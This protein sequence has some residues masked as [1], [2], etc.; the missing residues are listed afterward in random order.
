MKYIHV[1]LRLVWNI[2]TL[3]LIL[4]LKLIA[5]MLYLPLKLLNAVFKLFGGI[6]TIAGCI[7]SILSIIL[8]VFSHVTHIFANMEDG[9]NIFYHALW[10][11]MTLAIAA[12]PFWLTY[13]GANFLEKLSNLPLV[14]IF[15]PF[16]YFTIHIR[17]SFS[18]RYNLKKQYNDSDDKT[19]ENQSYFRQEN[20]D[21]KENTT[22]KD[23]SNWFMGVNDLESFKKRYRDLLKIYHPDNNAG[24]TLITQQIQ[25]EYN[26][27]LAENNWS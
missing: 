14:F 11:L 25:D 3:L 8:Y 26:R 15:M 22:E 9:Y 24:D 7:A 5:A 27:L 17:S 2:I 18:F 21:N 12:L 10:I 19:Y 1:A 23:I 6:L 16:D 20:L 4:V 13:Y